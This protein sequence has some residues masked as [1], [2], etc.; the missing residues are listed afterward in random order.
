MTGPLRPTYSEG[1]ILGAADLNAQVS[2]QRLGA[3]LHERTEHLWGVAQGL[4]L[5]TANNSDAGNNKFVDVSLSPGRAVDRLGRSIV[6]TTPL[7]LDPAV[8]VQQVANPGKTDF[9]PVFIQAIEVPQTGSP[10]PG[11]CAVSLST[12]IEESVQISFGRQGSEIAILDQDAATVDQGFGTPGLGDKV[13]VGWVQFLPDPVNK[14]SAVAAKANGVSI[15]YAGVVASDVVAGGGELMLHTRPSASRFALSIAETADGGCV[16]AFGKQDGTSPLVPTFSV[17]EK[18]N[19]THNGSLSPAP[20]SRTLAES[21][22]AFDGVRLP[23]PKGVTEDQF[24]QGKVRAHILVTPWPHQPA[25]QV[26][27]D[28]TTPVALPFVEFC[29]VDPNRTVRSAVRWVDPSNAATNY[30]V[31][32]SACT[33]VL[34]ASGQ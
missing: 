22:I 25:K 32:P 8:F 20:A 21:G 13:L 4:T 24:S 26:M 1:Q 18:G 7:P 27:P 16:L 23:L 6:V 28:G 14:F 15:R 9:F 2:Y 12:R 5:T 34:V 19:I 11:A 30:V 31:L 17:D 3:V 33:Y 10:Q 29:D